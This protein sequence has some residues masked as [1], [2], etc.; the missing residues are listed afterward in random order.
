MSFQDFAVL[1][2][3]TLAFFCA[4]KIKEMGFPVVLY[5]MDPEPSGFLKRRA[6]GGK[7]DY[8]HEE[9]KLLFEKLAKAEVPTLVVS[10]INPYILPEALLANPM[11]T[12]INCHQALL[13]RHPGRNAEM[14]AIFEGDQ[15]TGITWHMLTAEVDAGDILAQKEMAI[16][17]KHT[18]YQVF[19]EQILLAQEAFLELLPGLV[20]GELPGRPQNKEE[21]GKL[22]YSKDVPN[23]GI[24]DP[25]W[26]A[27]KT[28]AF[29]RAMDYGILQVVPRPRVRLG[30]REFTLGKYKIVKEQRFREGMFLE[31]DT[32][33]LQKP[34]ALFIMK[35]RP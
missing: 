23:Q 28:S 11:I 9:P 15:K 14:W 33:Y 35:V 22:H 7:V 31:A 26:D 5:E 32:I 2:T 10:A 19:R 30:G 24:L 12:A 29:L 34:E 17:E 8:A 21:R 6:V 27:G 4:A 20:K 13:P 16:S 1:G 3:G 25:G 18:S